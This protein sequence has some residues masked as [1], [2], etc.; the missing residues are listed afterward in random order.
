MKAKF[1]VIYDL[2]SKD[3]YKL[4]KD[5][6]IDL[7][8]DVGEIEDEICDALQDAMRCC[9]LDEYATHNYPEDMVEL[10]WLT[11]ALKEVTK[12]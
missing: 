3:I 10:T 1:T 11:K 12:K 4:A 5:Y 2:E 8:N 6:D 7:N 9:C